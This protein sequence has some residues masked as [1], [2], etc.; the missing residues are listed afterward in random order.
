MP[1]RNTT[2]RFGWLAKTF[3]WL[4]ALAIAGMIGFGLYFSGLPNGDEKTL[5]RNLHKS[6]GMVVLT[7]MVLRLLWR[8]ANPQPA[9]PAGT[10]A[11]QA[12][13]ATLTHWALYVAVFAQLIIGVLVSGQRPIDVFGLVRVPALLER[14]REQHEFFEELHECGWIVIAVLVGVHVL[15]A[16]YH[17]V[18][19]KDDVLKRMTTG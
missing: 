14:N 9:A 13:A 16:A 12:I 4:I 11:W 18:V 3:H 2:T 15:A 17:H 10:P 7:A 8:L 5:L 1:L 6:T 19:R